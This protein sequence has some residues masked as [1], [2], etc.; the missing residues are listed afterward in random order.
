MF[1]TE[2]T[3]FS[4]RRTVSGT[5]AAACALMLLVTVLM[6]FAAHAVNLTALPPYLS[7]NK[8]SPMVML[9]LSRDHQLFYKAYNEYSDLDGDGL[10][11]TQYKHTYR[12]YGYFDNQ[13]CYSYNTTSNRYVPER[14][15]NGSAATDPTYCGGAGEWHGNFLNWATTTRMDVVRRILYG[16]Y[17]S[18]DASIVS[19]TSLTVLE[20]AHLPTDAHA[21]AKYYS[22]TDIRKLT[23][24]SAVTEISICNASFKNGTVNYSHGA[25]SAPSIRVANGNFA[26]WNSNERWQCYWSEDKTATNGNVAANSGINASANNPSRA[27]NGLGT[28]YAAGSYTA[29]VEVCKT[30]LDSAVAPATGFTDDEKSRCKLYPLGNYKPVGLLQ[31]YG[32]SNQAAFGLMT[33]SFDK[34]ISGGVLRKNVASF[35]DEVDLDDGQFKTG[36]NGIVENLNALRIYGYDYRDGTYTGLDTCNFQLTSISEGSCTSWGNPMGEIYLESL[37]YLVGKVPG[38]P[39]T[40]ISPTTAFNNAAGA[41]DAAIGLTVAA[42]SDPFASTT[43]ASFGDPICRRTSVVN[44][45]ASVTSYDID[46]WGSQTDINGLSGA[47]TVAARTDQIGTS[48]GLYASGAK[49]A[50]GST[51]TDPSKICND[52]FFTSLAGVSG[53]C[54]EAPT[55]NGGYLMAGLALQAHTTPIRTDIYVP[56]TNTRAFRVDTYGVALATGTPRIKVPLPT[57]P[58]KFVIIQPAYRLVTGGGQGGGALVDFRVVSQTSTY[59]KYLIQWEDSEQGGDYDQDLWGT[60]EYT[61]VG[62]N[63]KISTQTFFEST[64]TAQGFGYVISGTGPT[65]AASQDGVHFHSGIENFYYVDPANISVTPTT[66]L[67][68]SGGCNPCNVGNGKTIATYS[69]LGVSGSVLHD[70]LYYAAKYGGFDRAKYSTT[71]YVPGN[72]LMP[73]AWDAKNTAGTTV[74]GGDG[75]PD[76]YFYAVDPGQ[77]ETSLEQIFQTILKAGGA[78]PAAATSSRTSAGGYVYTSTHSI[79]EAGA[80]VD[81]DVSGQFLRFGFAPDGNVS[82]TQDWDAGAVMTTQAAGSGWDTGRKIFTLSDTASVAFRWAKLSAVQQDVLRTNPAS[83]ALSTA[84]VGQARLNWLRGSACD[85]VA[86]GSTS[87]T[88]GCAASV[89][90][91]ARPVTKLGA[92]VNSTPWYVGQ[93]SAGYTNTEYDGGYGTFRT[94]N[95]ARNA[96]FVAANDGMVHGFSGATGSELLAYVPRALYTTSGTAPYSKLAAITA[97]DFSLGTGVDRMNADGS[98]MAADMKTGTTPTTLTWKTYLFGSFGRGAKGVFALDVT[99]PASV[100]ELDTDAANVVT[101]EFTESSDTDVPSDMGYIVGR[102]NTRSNGQPTQTGYMANK[103]W[104]VIF[105]NGYNSA[106][107]NAALYIL[108]AD[109]PATA[110]STTWT[111]GTHYKKIVVGTAGL[112][113]NNGLATPTAVDSNNDGVIDVIYAGDLK[114]N[115]WKFNVSDPNPANWGVATTGSV[116]SYQ[117]TTEVINVG[118]PSTT[119]TVAQP[120]TTAIVPFPHPQGGFQLFF[121]TGKVL[122]TGDYPMASP[123]SQ[124]IYGIYD[125]PGVSTAIT[126]GK[127]NLVKQTTTTVGG[128]RYFSQN[129]VSYPS[130]KGWYLDLPESS[131]SVIFNPVSEGAY[132]VNVRSLAPQ[133]TSDGCRYDATSFDATIN[134]I[135]GNPIVRLVPGA[136]LVTGYGAVGGS[137]QN[138][139]EFSKGGVFSAPTPAP[140]TTVCTA[141]DPDCVCNPA[142]PTEC[143]LCPDPLTCN[144]PWA[145]RAQNQCMFRT[146]TALGSGGI[147]TTQRFGACSDGRI[148]WREILRNQ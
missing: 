132:R 48:E 145:P 93:P 63:I 68:A 19:G 126:T 113:P 130:K 67:N 87:S 98:V 62:N 11:E 35:T 139:F 33:G 144:P 16:G 25:I 77:L 128:Y 127:T 140:S 142:V 95:A 123:Y 45:N 119:T 137:T 107:G 46:Q 4:S 50:V 121:G 20:R 120:I 99:N 24:F 92:I 78:A 114:G 27:T 37:R 52:K 53:I 44:F 65:V 56:T 22:G 124:T 13:R 81:A 66:N 122:E 138:A 38:S 106:S 55:A 115:V 136:P 73:D 109:G 105:G 42:W 43:T 97:K 60:L 29:R 40:Q 111:A 51:A 8:G 88:A 10:P 102:T 39:T 94:T 26:L 129:A 89:G 79:K 59:G 18:T 71:A 86:A 91:R 116:P 80:G 133:S 96:V 21:F 14:K 3:R 148:T 49:W 76:T 70:P 117:A 103:K 101:W 104:A 82:G 69:M 2:L 36:V 72:V 31:K 23:P 64:N 112:G 110:S 147:E 17:R 143:V 1:T 134:P 7:E 57:D 47:T 34:N 85:E 58:A 84:T 41:K 9:N 61:V 74:A 54:P 30:G 6:T 15:E 100:T 32:E 108:F 75:I 12:Y 125:Q 131:E 146:L 28:G 83:G 5:R 141:G 118:P 90:L 135:G